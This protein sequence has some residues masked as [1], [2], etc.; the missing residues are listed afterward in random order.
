VAHVA[1]ICP[2]VLPCYLVAIKRATGIRL[3]VLA[4]AATGPLVASVQAAC[5]AWLAAGLFNSPSLQAVAG[6]GLG[7]AC[8]L[9]LTAPQLVQV[10]GRGRAPHPLVSRILS[11][12][13]ELGQGYLNA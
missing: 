2:I 9:W 6:M 3:T 12:Y 1:I 8:Y 4:K 7:G 13:E 11:T 10:L 5:V